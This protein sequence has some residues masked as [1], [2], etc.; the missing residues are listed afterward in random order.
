MNF[1]E[2]FLFLVNLLRFRCSLPVATFVSFAQGEADGEECSRIV[3]PEGYSCDSEYLIRRMEKKS[4]KSS[5]IDKCRSFLSGNSLE[6]ELELCN[7]YD[8][9]IL[10]P[11]SKRFPLSLR[12]VEPLPLVLYCQGNPAYLENPLVAIVGARAST[13][14]GKSIAREIGSGLSSAGITVV[15]G[16][17]RGIDGCAHKGALGQKHV[18]SLFPRG[19]T[20]AVI[21]AGLDVPYPAEHEDLR[22]DLLSSGMIISEYPFGEQ[23]L[24]WHFPLRNRIIAGLC[25]SIVVVEACEGSGSLIT[26]KLA[27]DYGREVMAVPGDIVRKSSQGTNQL[28]RE[29]AALVR[30]AQDVIESMGFLGM[31]SNGE[32]PVSPR[33]TSVSIKLQPPLS[34]IV[35]FMSEGPLSLDQL[36]VKSGLA[37]G[38]LNRTLFQLMSRGL[39]RR[40]SGNMYSLV[41]SF[42]VSR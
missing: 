23:P 29:G 6:R 7:K 22:K 32:S 16:F 9:T 25:S 3:L 26:A 40:D 4:V 21:G 20:I 27:L 38:A 41:A 42:T 35:D 17:A 30:N 10:S 28:I 19:G 24:N 18:P 8:V 31:P 34:T 5:I 11:F 37:Y 14:G 36:V 13:S 39:I 33:D 2:R 1:E 15:S 12:Q